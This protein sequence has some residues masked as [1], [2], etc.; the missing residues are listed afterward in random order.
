LPRDLPA[1]VELLFTGHICGSGTIS[2]GSGLSPLTPAECIDDK[3]QF[4]GWI[5]IAV[6]GKLLTYNIIRL[7]R[8]RHNPARS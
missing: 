2:V 5:A 4:R 8:L 7:P 6:A 3:E 1:N